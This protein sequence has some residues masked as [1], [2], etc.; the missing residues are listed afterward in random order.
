PSA[1]LTCERRMTTTVA[2]QALQLLNDEFTN[3]QAQFMAARVMHEVGDDVSKQIE[4]AYWLALLRPPTESQR[5]QATQFVQQ[6]FETQH[7]KLLDGRNNF[8]PTEEA[9]LHRR[10][11]ADL[12]QVL[13]NSN[14]FVYV[15]ESWQT[16]QGKITIATSVFGRRSGIAVSFCKLL[17]PVLPLWPC[18]ICSAAMVYWLSHR[19][20]WPRPQSARAPHQESRSLRLRQPRNTIRSPPSGPIS[21]PKPKA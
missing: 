19:N 15:N 13:F 20:E 11:L 2:T 16:T 3:D 7:Q 9:Q 14:D 12:C 8:S 5:Q 21:P 18:S 6:Q 4:R 1:A 17:A 10:A